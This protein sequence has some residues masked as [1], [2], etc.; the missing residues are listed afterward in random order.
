MKQIFSYERILKNNLDIENMRD[1]EK[2]I[3]SLE[4]E[5]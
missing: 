3:S 4:V 1:Y 2:R 5:N